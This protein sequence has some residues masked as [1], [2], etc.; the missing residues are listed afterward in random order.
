M[1]RQFQTGNEYSQDAATFGGRAAVSPNDPNY[2]PGFAGSGNQ[3]SSA[4]QA[5]SRYQ[6]MGANTAAAATPGSYADSVR[7][8]MQDQKFSRNAQNDAL[9]L[10]RNA[11]M[12]N[13]PSQA[14]ILGRQQ[15]DNGINS[16]MA[17]AASA[18]GGPLGVAAATRQAQFQ[19][20]I[21]QQ[22]GAQQ[23]QAG[24]AQEMADAM[25]R[26]SNAANAQMGTD[27]QRTQM[28]GG[29]NLQQQQ[30]N[31]Q[32]R[33]AGANTQLGYEQLGY[34]VNNAQL[35]A[36][37]QART[38]SNQA[39]QFDK[40]QAYKSDQNTENNVFGLVGGLA[41][42]IVASDANLKQNITPLGRDDLMGTNGNWD[43]RLTNVYA[44]G[45]Q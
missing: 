25:G 27:L 35:Q 2:S 28:M 30:I 41:S 42:G 36:G 26:Y 9:S 29:M 21:S 38:I 10:Q 12:G 11:A 7:Q 39:Q 22:Q 31:N 16:Q 18:R 32:N 33:Q 40:E 15:I 23:I 14:E 44:W 13:A 19:G 3:Q 8:G 1:G 17:M 24:R 34:N 20:A 37:L 5:V 4:Q 45:G 43:P 6:T